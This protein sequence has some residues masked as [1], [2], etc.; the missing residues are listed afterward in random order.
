MR[1]A[2]PESF[3]ARTT[4]RI[5]RQSMATLEI[6]EANFSD[7]IKNQEIVLLDWWASW[8]GPCRA[9][10]PHFEAAATRHADVTFGKVNTETETNL[11]AAFEIRSIP[12][13]LA[14]RQG[15]LLFSQAGM[16]PPAAMDELVAKIRAL[17]MDEVRKQVEAQ[18]GEENQEDQDAKA[19]E[20]TD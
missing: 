11:A 14:F 5:G 8:C 9:F 18:P 20:S 10:A 19:A 13:L 7:T 2:E 3:C 15:I 1:Y 4:L 16:M 6:T 17:D 12:T